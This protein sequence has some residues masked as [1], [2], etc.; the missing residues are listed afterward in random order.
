M[1]ES[2]HPPASSTRAEAR[3]RR[4]SRAGCNAAAGCGN[5]AKPASE[6]VA[7]GS[8]ERKV[9]GSCDDAK[10]SVDRKVIGGSVQ[11]TDAKGPADWSF[12]VLM[13]EP[14]IE[15]EERTLNGEV[16]FFHLRIFVQERYPCK[17][18]CAGCREL[19]WRLRRRQSDFRRL[20]TALRGA[21]VLPPSV[22]LP[23]NSFFQHL[24]PSQTHVRQRADE[25][26]V[27]LR[28]ALGL[29]LAAGA[30][31][32][33]DDPEG[34]P[35]CL[36]VSQALSQFLGLED[37]DAPPGSDSDEEQRERPLLGRWRLPNS[38]TD[39]QC[40]LVYSMDKGVY[41]WGHHQEGGQCRIKRVDK[42]ATLG[43]LVATHAEYRGAPGAPSQ[44]QTSSFGSSSTC[45]SPSWSPA[46]SPAPWPSSPPSR[47]AS[48]PCSPNESLL[49]SPC[50]SP[51]GRAL[52]YDEEDL[53]CGASVWSLSTTDT[54]AMMAEMETRPKHVAAVWL[55]VNLDTEVGRRQEHAKWAARVAALRQP[56]HLAK[57]VAITTDAARAKTA[58]DLERTA[59]LYRELAH[60]H[61][62]LHPIL[63]YGVDGKS[64]VVVQE[65][66][67]GCHGLRGLPFTP[68]RCQR[69]LF[70]VLSGLAK[71]HEQ[72]MPHGYVSPESLVI[73]NNEQVR[74]AWT[75]AQRRTEGH[76]GATV[77]F[78]APEAEPGTAGDIWAL[79][80]VVLV[81]WTG[82]AAAPHPWTQFAKSGR[83]QQNIQEAL[84][85]VP[86][87]L[88]QALLDLHTAAASADEPEH[89]FLLALANLLTRCFC[90]KASERPS[91][92]RLLQHPFFE[93]AL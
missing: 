82:F 18:R 63:G 71:L 69:V 62:N 92:A 23:K 32:A 2:R 11:G 42:K 57:E 74:L 1:G 83:P 72:Q 73:N 48:F 44:S 21:D 4:Y 45:T 33:A 60:S 86:P 85:K 70:G 38:A 80:S 35:D 34:C 37:G 7:D 22:V 46:M 79:A 14:T 15:H 28:A 90:W 36:G 5:D 20:D 12:E 87:E 53:S 3:Q 76:T 77:G 58:A 39:R 6:T 88:P 91:A 29:A 40:Q 51:R 56:D 10:S 24:C 27:Y 26:L 17:G 9:S 75:P 65:D 67:P 16:A 89:M 47:Q 31:E 61:V 78:R 13:E 68:Q 54:D 59:A 64:F 30:A 66:A 49:P 41:V 55:E 19:S 52:T 8:F 93:Q 25:L 43:E 50:L 81:W 84:S